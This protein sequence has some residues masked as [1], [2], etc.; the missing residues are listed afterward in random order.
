MFDCFVYEKV[1]KGP[2]NI[3]SCSWKK[4]ELHRYKSIIFHN[5]LNSLSILTQETIGQSNVCNF[6]PDLIDF[7]FQLNLDKLSFN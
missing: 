6:Q 4:S 7:F 1:Y 2:Y 5:I 3:Y